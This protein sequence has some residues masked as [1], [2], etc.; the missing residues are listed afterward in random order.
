MLSFV[1]EILNSLELFFKY[2][3]IYF[4]AGSYYIGLV[5]L[6]LTG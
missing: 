6:E 2:V 5:D 4:E 3:F 1:F